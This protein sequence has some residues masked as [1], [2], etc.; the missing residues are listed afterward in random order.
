MRINTRKGGGIARGKSSRGSKQFIQSRSTERPKYQN[1]VQSP[2]NTQRHPR[3]TLNQ[4]TLN[5][6]QDNQS[7]EQYKVKRIFTKIERSY[8]VSRTTF[9]KEIS[10]NVRLVHSQ[11]VY[12]CIKGRVATL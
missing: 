7:Q 2:N 9:A 3:D 10:T 1:R 8:D 5:D 11:R 6:N 4:N 12:L